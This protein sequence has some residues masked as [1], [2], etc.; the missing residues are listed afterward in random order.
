MR[1][2]II[3]AFTAWCCVFTSAKDIEV[4]ST[5]YAPHYSLND[6]KA[7]TVYQT[8]RVPLLTFKDSGTGRLAEELFTTILTNIPYARTFSLQLDAI[9]RDTV[10]SIMEHEVPYPIIEQNAYGVYFFNYQGRD[11]KVLLTND[12]PSFTK[13]KEDVTP[14]DKNGRPYIIDDIFDVS[15]DTIVFIT[16][17]IYARNVWLKDVLNI[18]NGIL[19]TEKNEIEPIRYYYGYDRYNNSYRLMEL[20]KVLSTFIPMR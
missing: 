12:N 9:G 19:S 11:V 14:T 20:Y 10:W 15:D 1:Q 7:D 17:I 6:E 2:L 3:I 4:K 13:L 18:W 8:Y 16:K 5:V